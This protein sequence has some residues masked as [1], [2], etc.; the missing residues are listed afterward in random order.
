MALNSTFHFTLIFCRFQ[1]NQ[2][3]YKKTG[4]NFDPIGNHIRILPGMESLVMNLKRFQ[5]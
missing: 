5:R 2:K 1:N 3:N 4:S